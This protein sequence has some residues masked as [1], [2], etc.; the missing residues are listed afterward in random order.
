[1][2]RSRSTFGDVP[3]GQGSVLSAVAGISAFRTVA[4]AEQ[5]V[6]YSEGVVPTFALKK[7]CMLSKCSKPERNAISLKERSVVAISSLIRSRETDAISIVLK[8]AGSAQPI[9]MIAIAIFRTMTV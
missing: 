6:R 1:M 3:V 8:E 5:V 9:G 4:D 7:R 2:S